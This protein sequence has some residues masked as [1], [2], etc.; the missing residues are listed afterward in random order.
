MGG[1]CSIY[2]ERK[3]IYEV[4]CGKLEERHHLKDPGVDWIIILRRIFRKW[5]EDIDWSDLA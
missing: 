4:L 1:A 5:D 3:S 2:G